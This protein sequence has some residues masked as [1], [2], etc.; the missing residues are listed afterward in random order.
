MKKWSWLVMLGALL[1]PALGTAQATS[2]EGK[3][4]EEAQKASMKYSVEFALEGIAEEDVRFVLSALEREGLDQ[5]S[6]TNLG[7][8]EEEIRWTE[9]NE[10]E[11]PETIL[12]RTY[13]VMDNQAKANFY[14]VSVH[15][16]SLYAQDDSASTEKLAY[17]DFQSHISPNIPGWRGAFKNL[18]EK[19][20]TATGND[21]L[22]TQLLPF[23][24]KYPLE[25]I[26][27]FSDYKV[28]SEEGS[29]HDGITASINVNFRNGE[30][31]TIKLLIEK[32]W[33]V[34]G[35][36][37]YGVRSWEVRIIR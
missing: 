16:S 31:E 3:L 33:A 9:Q 10:D 25:T 8:I 30:T 4:Q 11:T 7:K 36:G 23:A 6:V 28:I 22:K 32:P 17:G 24:K 21:K 2:L 12:T 19:F 1:F 14:A 5:Y 35:R 29:R 27:D 20:A 15:H 26:K 37:A 18:G 13:Y 34:S